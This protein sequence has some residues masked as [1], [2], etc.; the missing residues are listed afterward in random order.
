MKLRYAFEFVDMGDE[1]IAVPVGESAVELKGVLK[2][3][4]FGKEI[5]ELMENEVSESEIINILANR[6]DNSKESLVGYVQSFLKQLEEQG[7]LEK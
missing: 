2:L 7:L 4:K 1:I 5:S 3:N 6:Y